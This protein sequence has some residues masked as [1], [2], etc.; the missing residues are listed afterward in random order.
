MLPEVPTQPVLET[1]T[2]TPSGPVYFTST[3]PPCRGPCPTP[4]ARFTSSRG[5]EPAAASLAVM[6]SRLSTSKPMWWMPLYAL[7]RST[8]ATAS[9]LNLRMARFRS[10]SLR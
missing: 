9:L 5:F 2:M 10:P 8:P 3:L 7:P 4:S 1:S 6:S